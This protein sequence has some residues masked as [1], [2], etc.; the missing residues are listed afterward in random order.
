MGALDE[1]AFDE[2]LGADPDAALGLLADLRGATDERLRAAARALAGRVVL[3]L[4][5]TG[6]V[7]RRGVG[8]F[9]EVTADRSAADVDID[10]SLDALV[11]AR[12]R[13][14][15][16]HLGD[17]RSREWGRPELA[18]CLVVDRSGSM[19]GERLATAAIAASACAWRAPEDSSVLAFGERVIVLAAQGQQRP[20]EEIVDD[21]FSLRGH[22]PTDLDLA[23][24]TAG[25]QLQRSRATRRLTVV[26]SDARPTKGADPGPAAEELDELVLIAPADD[27]ED[28][29]RFADAVG[30][31]CLTLTGPSS[32]PTVLTDAFSG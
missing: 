15:T 13:G 20:V 24:R 22:G 8:R 6:A 26:L 3:D 12:G 14:E 27:A 1:A 25:D 2:L 31:R 7:R 5:R 21:L 18:V 17:L 29:E 19:G 10:R 16:P 30:A 4:G 28:A 32:V 23:L 11:A 9:R